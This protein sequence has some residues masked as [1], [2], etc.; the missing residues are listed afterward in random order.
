MNEVPYMSRLKIDAR[1][2]TKIINI[3]SLIVNVAIVVIAAYAVCLMMIGG[4]ENNMAAGVKTFRYFTNLS[5][6]LVAAATMF[7]IPFNINSIISGKNELPFWTAVCR[8]IGAVAV[9]E[10]F[11][12]CVVFLGPTQGFKLVF[13][14]AGLY[15][16]V[17]VPVLAIIAAALSENKIPFKLSFLGLLPTAL[18]SIVY[19]IEV[20]LVKN[21]PDFYGFTFGGNYA[22]IP[23]SVISTYALTAL[24]SMGLNY[25]RNAIS[26]AIDKK[27]SSQE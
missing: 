1:T 25:L 10:T 26:V 11:I 8:F 18:Y 5:N 15:L 14:G 19:T 12:T 17:I 7:V 6:I 9:A 21:W 22:L 13:S 20:L 27:I 23:L 24:I 4:K 16:H 2:K 3:C